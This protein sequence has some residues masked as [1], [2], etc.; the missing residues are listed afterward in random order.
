MG[1]AAPESTEALALNSLL[2]TTSHAVPRLRF[3]HRVFQEFF[4]A[5]ASARFSDGLLPPEVERWMLHP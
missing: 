1:D 3:A 5:E 2:I 4:V